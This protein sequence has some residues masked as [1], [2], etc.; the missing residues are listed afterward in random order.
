MELGVS[1]RSGGW[2]RCWRSCLLVK[3]GRSEEVVE[4]MVVLLVVVVEGE[5]GWTGSG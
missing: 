4:W 3:G 5:H 2:R 1:D